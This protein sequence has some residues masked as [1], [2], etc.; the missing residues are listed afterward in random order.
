VCEYDSSSCVLCPAGKYSSSV[1]S[2]SCT[3]CP[4]G[5]SSDG[6][7]C[8]ACGPGFYFNVNSGYCSVCTP[9]K[10]ST[11]VANS[12][13]ISCS[14]G[15][16]TRGNQYSNHNEASDC[17]ACPLGTFFSNTGDPS[18]ILRL[19]GGPSAR[20]GRVEL[21]NFRTNSWG[22]IYDRTWRRENSMVCTCT[23]VI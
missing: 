9:G 12:A 5:Y 21:Y 17:E 2:L 3:S 18:S 14:A 11:S 20:E 22:S 7:N 10:Y 8:V 13:C 23:P 6:S 16:A 4:D 15:T 19:A 1:G